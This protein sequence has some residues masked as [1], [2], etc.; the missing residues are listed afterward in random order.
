MG[1][2]EGDGRIGVGWIKNFKIIVDTLHG[3]GSIGS[4]RDSISLQH[5]FSRQHATTPQPIERIV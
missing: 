1:R 5:S 2:G 4:M 3:L